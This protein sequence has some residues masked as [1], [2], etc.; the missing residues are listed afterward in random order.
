VIAQM[1]RARVGPQVLVDKR[2]IEGII[3]GNPLI[4]E[5]LRTASS[6]Y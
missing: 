5:Q 3:E 6:R 1:H 2:L 4:L